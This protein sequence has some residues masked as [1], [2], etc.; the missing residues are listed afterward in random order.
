LVYAS[1]RTCGCGTITRP[2][3]EE[4][5]TA[6]RVTIHQDSLALTLVG[7]SA[8]GFVA[9]IAYVAIWQSSLP[10]F[11]PLHYNGVGS[12]DLIGPKSDLFK[13]PAIGVAVT[14]TDVILAT[15]LHRRERWAA[16]ALLAIS[17]LVQIILIVATLNI[18]RLAF[19]D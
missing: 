11:L 5:A 8:L 15:L 12:V 3:F 2:P 7:L 6:D 14:F 4:A 10:P 13:M 1:L 18:V 9:L 16:L 19:G 17:V